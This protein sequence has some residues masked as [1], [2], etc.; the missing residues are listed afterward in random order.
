ML[1]A[2]VGRRHGGKTKATGR[3][4]KTTTDTA[5]TMASTTTSTG[6]TMVRT[7]ATVADALAWDR[8]GTGW[9]RI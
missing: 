7:T 5:T 4:S 2:P 8:T 3:V 6:T 9:N 1:E